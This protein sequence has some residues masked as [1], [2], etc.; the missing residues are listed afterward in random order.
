M[1]LWTRSTQIIPSYRVLQKKTTPY[2]FYPHSWNIALGDKIFIGYIWDILESTPIKYL[3]CTWIFAEMAEDQSQ[4]TFFSFDQEWSNNWNLVIHWCYGFAHKTRT[5]N[6][7]KAVKPILELGGIYETVLI[8]S[9]GLNREYSKWGEKM[10]MMSPSD[11][12]RLWVVVCL[13]C[14]W[15]NIHWN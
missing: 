2:I 6:D 11:T 15:W 4:C 7:Q 12:M 3:D 5:K 8:N 9:I 1:S 13:P 14:Q 10:F